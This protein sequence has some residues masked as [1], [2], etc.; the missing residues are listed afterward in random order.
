MLRIG[1]W[2]MVMVRSP[3]KRAW[4]VFLS[5]YSTPKGT[6]GLTPPDP[7]PGS[8]ALRLDPRGQGLRVQGLR[9]LGCAEFR[10]LEIWGV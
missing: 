5:P 2:D 8:Q 7:G 4:V 6:P 9:D 1:L 10:G 3:P